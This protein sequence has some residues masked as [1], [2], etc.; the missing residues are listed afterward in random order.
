MGLQ[1]RLSETLD[2]IKRDSLY[3][4]ERIITS[5]DSTCARRM[6]SIGAGP[7][8]ITAMPCSATTWAAGVFFPA[9]ETVF[10]AIDLLPKCS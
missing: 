4:E 8:S 5:P 6:N 7:A 10:L 9:R 1:Q 3:K 2:Q